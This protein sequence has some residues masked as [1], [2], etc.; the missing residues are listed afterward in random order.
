MLERLAQHQAFNAMNL[1]GLVAARASLEDADHV[2]RSRQKNAET[3][4]WLVAE[5]DRLGHR[6]LPSEANFV[7]IDLRTEVR[8][9]IVALRE[10]GVRVG[11]VFPAMPSHMR[12]T[13][14]TPEEM[15][16]FVEALK[17]AR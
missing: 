15:Q 12:L 8:P 9:V 1:L 13:I 7:M 16:T 14:G 3:R 2:T 6:M 4:A 5:L 11:R 10:H 17:A